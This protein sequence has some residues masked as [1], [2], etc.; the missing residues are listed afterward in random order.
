MPLIEWHPALELGVPQMDE[1]HRAFL[2]VLNGLADASDEQIPAA[3]AALLQHTL[4]HFEQERRWMVAMDFPAS[5]C[6]LAEHEGVLEV[7][8]EVQAYL[9]EGKLEVG[10][11][12]ARE[13]AQWFRG[14]AATMD[15]M[16]AQYMQAKPMPVESAGAPV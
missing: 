12:L 11:V 14:H 4:V 10:R 16:L 3:F 1:T 6:H 2:A 9:Q 7:M 13:L 5:H 15:A 8:R